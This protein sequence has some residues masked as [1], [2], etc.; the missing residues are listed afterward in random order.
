M[1]N[2]DGDGDEVHQ[3]PLTGVGSTDGSEAKKSTE[4]GKKSSKKQPSVKA[5]KKAGKDKQKTKKQ[6]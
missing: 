6:R 2:L 4:S 3:K 1:G 5:T